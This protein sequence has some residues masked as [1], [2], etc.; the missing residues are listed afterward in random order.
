MVRPRGLLD[1][2]RRLTYIIGEVVAVYG[3]LQQVPGTLTISFSVDDAKPTL[4]TP[5][6][7][8]QTNTSEWIVG[9]QLFEMSV[10][11]GPH[12]L[13]VSL[14]EATG[15]QVHT[16]PDWPVLILILQAQMLWL[17]SIGIQAALTTTLSNVAG[18]S[19]SGS[20]VG[21]TGA[22]GITPVPT[23][24][25]TTPSFNTNTS[26]GS[27]LSGGAIG[28]LAGGLSVFAAIVLFI[29][30]RWLAAR[31]NKP[32]PVPDP[33]P[34]GPVPVTPTTPLYTPPPPMHEMAPPSPPLTTHPGP[35]LHQTLSNLFNQQHGGQTPPLQTHWDL[36]DVSSGPTQPSQQGSS[37]NLRN[38][39][40]S[41][42]PEV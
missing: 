40:Y 16:S 15:S 28:G 13:R 1:L 14:Q 23:L 29:L 22:G 37:S 31:R 39:H 42:Q 20:G 34:V 2:H 24:G 5:W 10:S 4:Y 6:N 30:R 17:D 35:S 21:T 32:A 27:G 25:T 38:Y 8:T 41:G 3:V 18:G 12:T 36:D 9:F 19:G 11:A 26:S 33:G 7:G